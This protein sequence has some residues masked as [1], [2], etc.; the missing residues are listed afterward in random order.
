MDSRARKARHRFA[1]RRVDAKC[2]LGEH[3]L[4]F[5]TGLGAIK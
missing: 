3:S 5:L 2:F 4:D 1:A